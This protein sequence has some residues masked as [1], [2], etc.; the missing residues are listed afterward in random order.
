MKAGVTMAELY[1]VILE[2]LG[3]DP[4]DSYVASLIARGEDAVLKKIG[5]ECCE[6]LLAAK[7]GRRGEMVHE[8]ADLWFHLLVWMAGAGVKPEEVER[9]LG[10]RFGRSGLAE[11]SAGSI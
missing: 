3:A 4:E 10:A 1:G 2:R 8:L 5:E 7:N 9:E 11:K 6:L